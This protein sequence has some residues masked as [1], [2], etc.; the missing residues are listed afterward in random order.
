[1][2]TCIGVEPQRHAEDKYVYL[3]WESKTSCLALNVVTV[4]IGLS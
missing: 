1:M 4:F 2:K 3:C